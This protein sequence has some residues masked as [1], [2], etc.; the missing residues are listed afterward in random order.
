MD[1][2]VVID[3][4][5]SR[6]HMITTVNTTIHVSHLTSVTII[7][8]INITIISN[9]I[10]LRRHTSPL[11]G[12]EPAGMALDVDVD[13]AVPAAAGK[14][15]GQVVAEG[16]LVAVVV[17]GVLALVKVCAGWRWWC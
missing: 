15:A 8:I 17:V 10:I 4:V 5:A 2:I 12:A 6:N 13:H 14:R 7:I 3:I 9:S 11:T 16:A 1:M